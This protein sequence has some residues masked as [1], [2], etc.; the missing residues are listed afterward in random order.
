MSDDLTSSRAITPAV[1][2]LASLLLAGCASSTLYQPQRTI[3][4]VPEPGAASARAPLGD[5]VSKTLNQLLER[6]GDF[7]PN[8]LVRIRF[9]YMPSLDS[10]QRVLVSGEISP[11]L[12]APLQTRG[13]TASELQGR[14]QTLYRPLLARPSVSVQVLEYARPPLPPEIF[15]MGEVARP[16]AFA[17]R[18]GSSLFEALARAG[19][20]SR[21]A[22]L[23]QVVL[24]TPVKGQLEAEMI[25]LRAV[26]DGSSAQLRELRPFSVIIIPATQSARAADRAR[27]IRQIIG[28]NGIN[29]GSSVTLVSP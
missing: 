21:D 26:L 22:D 11:P 17:Y 2:G 7:S 10:E 24:L 27:Q 4:L 14:L 29:L 3:A 13:M 1:A 28:F 6:P 19:G 15:V 12:L 25:D 23:G 18:D 5:Q 9:P 20:A 16:G 8:D